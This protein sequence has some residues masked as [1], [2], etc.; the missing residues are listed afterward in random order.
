M[1]LQRGLL[2]RISSYILCHGCTWMAGLVDTMKEGKGSQLTNYDLLVLL[3]VGLLSLLFFLSS[4]PTF[5]FI[6]QLLRKA[7]FSEYSVAFSYW[8]A[9]R[10]SHQILRSHISRTAFACEFYHIYQHHDLKCFFPRQ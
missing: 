1:H 6:V 5:P 9:D 10:A 3:F 2:A 8:V 4:F 7:S